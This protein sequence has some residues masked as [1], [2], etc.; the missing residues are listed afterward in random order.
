MILGQT[1][2]HYVVEE[3]LG[4]GGMG[5][6]YRATDTRLGRT[7]ALK[8]L[9][10]TFANDP[11]RA[12][13][14]DREARLLASLNH[15]N[16]AAIYGL[17]ASAGLA[18]LV[19]EH[20][21]GATLAE[22]LARGPLP[23]RAALAIG[24]QIADAL[25]AAHERGIIHR[26]LKPAN[27]KVTDDDKVKVLDFGVA[28]TLEHARGTET[29]DTLTRDATM[30][31]VILGT[32]PYMSPEQ[33]CGKPLDTR[34][35]IWSFGC[36]LYEALTGTRTFKGDTATEV[37][38]GIVEREPDWMLLQRANVPAN[39]DQLIRRCLQKDPRGR[40]R[41]MG[42]A[43]I[44][45]EETLAGKI[46]ATLPTGAPRSMRTLIAAAAALVL[47]A[48]GA[49]AWVW[50]QTTS[51]AA[52]S[53]VRFTIDV[54]QGQ[55]FRPTWNPQIGFSRDGNVLAYSHVG[56]GMSSARTYL[57]RLDEIESHTIPDVA[58]MPFQAFSPDGTQV[59][60]HL[61]GR[62]A[63]M[64]ASVSGGTA[65]QLATADFVFRGDWGPDD[66]YYFT[67]QFFGPIVRM[68]TGGGKQEPVTQ[69]DLDKG[70]RTHRHAVVL[71]GAKAIMFTV[72]AGGMESFD[73]ARID[74]Y[75]LDTKTRK[76]LIAG[77]FA[78]RY[79]PSGHI[80]YARGGNLYAVAFDAD[81]LEVSGSPMKVAEGVMMST[82]SGAA[83][84]DVSSA[85]ALTY[86]AGKA[87]GG[88]RTL[89]W[90]DRQGKPTPLPLPARP[91]AFPRV[92][93][94][95]SRIAFEIEGVNHD[96]HVYDPERD[97]TTTMTTD[98]MSHAPV[99][100]PD[101]RRI[102]YRSW[103]A[104]TMTMWWMPADKSGPEE[105]LTLVGSRQSVDSFSP[106]GRY[107]AFNQMELGSTGP[108]VWILPIAED[109]TPV[110]F[111]RSR[112]AEGSAKFSPDGKWVAYCTNEPGK[113]EV[114]VQAWPQGPIT[115][116][117]SGGGTD[118]IWSR[119]G[120]E[121]FYRNG[122][123]MMV[124][125]VSTQPTFKASR[126]VMLW[127][128]RYSHGMSSSCAPAGPTETNYAVSVDGQRFLMVKDAD[129][130][131]TSTRIVVVLNFLE[132]LRPTSSPPAR[133]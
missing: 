28:K 43:R 46:P 64:K 97:V 45:L 8:L 3:Q 35:D 92:S 60:L 58:P 112:F 2:D 63:L 15:P 55:F 54:P 26:D 66:Y 62:Q 111:A 1:L 110:P 27:V 78:A 98:G 106:D 72:A 130:D 83:N 37:I 36:V 99:W 93:P 101:G 24:L 126:P 12:A 48:T 32:A 20:V 65:V 73:D 84:F 56:P 94:D 42:D 125:E 102:A 38:A 91:Y 51:G 90:V 68:P 29:G 77:G 117:S 30:A 17:E 74:V 96:L 39:V 10:E 50:S 128:G 40:L 116:V 85:G 122:D 11:E 71:P 6:V 81:R 115:Q 53:V 14:L 123:K 95:G 49:A 61:A 105:R 19:L 67:N 120:K 4:A 127:E 44:E 31:G 13:R 104:G 113:A 75:R 52:P 133:R 18:F 70:E 33:A 23:L 80:V 41:S 114:Y 47:V 89:V 7:V 132:M 86:V 121:L 109:R 22:R 57:R 124:V 34:T 88:D 59:L 69:L 87:E 9:H 21:P 5:V 103:K 79:S 108:D 82:N 118:P 16:I 129:Q 25:E 119:D 107:A 131:V 100:T 76:T